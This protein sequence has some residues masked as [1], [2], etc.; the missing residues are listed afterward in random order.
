MH[1][2]WVAVTQIWCDLAAPQGPTNVGGDLTDNVFRATLQQ[3]CFEGNW[4]QG[5]PW[6]NEVNKRSDDKFTSQMICK[7]DELIKKKLWWIFLMQI[8]S[9]PNPSNSILS[10]C[11]PDIMRALILGHVEAYS[12][13]TMVKTNN[14]P[15]K[16][17][18]QHCSFGL[19]EWEGEKINKDNKIDRSKKL[20]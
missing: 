8:C 5:L 19:R 1:I 15:H 2:K 14:C 7:K 13:V 11:F 10:I 17:P 20:L 16:W 9:L 3:G 4:T 18:L 12:V 6:L